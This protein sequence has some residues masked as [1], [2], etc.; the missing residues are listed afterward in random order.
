MSA[1]EAAM[2]PKG[3]SF[4]SREKLTLGT[5]TPGVPKPFREAI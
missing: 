5:Q 1:L 3:L 2:V 4:M